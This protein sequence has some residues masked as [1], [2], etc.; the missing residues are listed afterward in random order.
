[1]DIKLNLP[2]HECIML[3]AFKNLAIIQIMLA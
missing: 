1:M 2:Y 3:D